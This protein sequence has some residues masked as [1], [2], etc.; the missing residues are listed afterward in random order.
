MP[1][2]RCDIDVLGD[3]VLPAGRGQLDLQ[4]SSGVSISFKNGAVDDEGHPTGMEAV[5]IGPSQS[6]ETAASDLRLALT[7]QLDLLTFV[8]H[9]R[10][11]IVAPRRLIEWDAGQTQRTMKVFHTV[12]SR[13]PPDPELDLAYFDTV[14]ALNRVPPPPF[15]RTALKYFRYGLLDDLAEDQFMRIWLSL[16]IIAESTKD[17]TPIPI[18]CPICQGA[19]TCSAC[20][21]KPTRTRM[22]KQ[23]I[24][25]LI[26][27]IAGDNAAVISKRLFVARNGLME[28]LLKC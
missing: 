7:E 26:R 19:M 22:A 8:T 11:K 17:N 28:D 10:F 6:I 15:V 14:D 20:G 13:Y 18:A 9:S 23:A 2:F 24:E 4:T 5:V 25:G 21:A 16:E 12:D 27:T 3:L 1:T